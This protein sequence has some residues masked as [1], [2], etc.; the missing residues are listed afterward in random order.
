MHSY[1]L[2]NLV[3]L[4]E[5]L[6]LTAKHDRQVRRNLKIRGAKQLRNLFTYAR[7]T[8]KTPKFISPD[9]LEKLKNIEIVLNSEA[10][11][12]STEKP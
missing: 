7:K 4:A 11:F 5:I 3:F 10:E 9:N 1:S 8:R 6:L 12:S 2:C